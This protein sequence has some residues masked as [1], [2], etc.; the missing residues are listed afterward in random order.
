MIILGLH[1]GHNSSASLMKDGRIIAAINEERITRHKNDVGYPRNAINECLRITKVKPEDIDIVACST[2]YIAIKWLKPKREVMFSVNDYVKE[3]Y[4]WF[5]PL[6]PCRTFD[7]RNPHTVL[8]CDGLFMS[9][10][11]LHS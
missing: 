2:K 1:E 4:E 7:V 9:A 10:C 5:K 8:Q 11:Y 6:I 3:Q